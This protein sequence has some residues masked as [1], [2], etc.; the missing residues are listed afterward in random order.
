MYMKILLDHAN[1]N[2]RKIKIYRDKLD[3]SHQSFSRNIPLRRAF[4]SRDANLSNVTRDKV[5]RIHLY[6]PGIN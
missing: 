2:V 3:L 1:R 4:V 5:S 6:L